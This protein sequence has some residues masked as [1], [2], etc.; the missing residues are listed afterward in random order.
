MNST[1]LFYI[2]QYQ[3]GTLNF[4]QCELNVCYFRIKMNY[5][6]RKAL[7]IR[8]V[9]IKIPYKMFKSLVFGHFE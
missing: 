6:Q 4:V 8:K 1:V 7:N 3:N 2:E 5:L 9:N